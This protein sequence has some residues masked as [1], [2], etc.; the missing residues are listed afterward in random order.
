MGKTI[1]VHRFI[2]SIYSD[3][4]FTTVGVRTDKKVLGVADQDVKMVLWDLYGED[5]FQTL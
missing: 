1:L 3:A 4:Y 5:D 2:H